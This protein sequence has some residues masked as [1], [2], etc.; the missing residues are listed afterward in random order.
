[1]QQGQ[2]PRPKQHAL[3]R[4]ALTMEVASTL[5]WEHEIFKKRSQS[6]DQYVKPFFL[7]FSLFLSIFLKNL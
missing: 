4:A 5:S 6:S 7:P 3:L 1:M 2:T